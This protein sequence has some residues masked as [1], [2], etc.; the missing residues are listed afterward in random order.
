MGRAIRGLLFA[1][2]A[3]VGAYG[4]LAPVAD[5]LSVPTGGPKATFADS[6]T[7]GTS[8]AIASFEAAAGGADNGTTAGE[9][10]GGFRHVN[11]DGLAVDGSDPGSTVIKGG[12]VAAAPSRLQPWGLEL[13]PN[14]AISNN[15][16]QSV[17]TAHFTPFS[18]PN[19]WGTF[20]TGTAEFDV[21]A[22]VG[23]GST[24][25]PAQTRGLGIVFLNATA[26]TQITYYNG[27]IALDSVSPPASSGPSFAGLLYPDP[28]VT[29]VVVTLGGGQ[30]FGYDGTTV[31]PGGSS[32]AAGD[33]V[34]LA[35]PAPARPTVSATAGVP[36]SP[37][38]DTFTN[39]G[40]GA[41][42]TI[43]WGDGTG[44]AGTIVPASGGA[45]N[46]TGTHAYAQTG[47]YTAKVVVDDFFGHEQS[48]QTTIQVGPRA[49]TTSVSCSPAPVAV[50]APTTCTATVAD[51]GGAVTPTGL[52]SFSTP[53]PGASFGQDGGCLLSSTAIAGL[54]ACQVRFTPGQL[55]PLQARITA[56]YGGDGAHAGSGGIASV[57]V[58][59]QRCSVRALSRRLR[60]AGLGLLV[61]CDA[62]SSVRISVTAVGRRAGASRS[63]QLPFGSL[64]ALVTEGRPTV[65]V[66]KPAAGVEPVLRAALRRHQPVS[67][68]LALT[69]SSHV[70][71][72]TTTTRLAAV[73]IL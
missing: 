24:A 29:R 14:I 20:N 61:T 34:L 67:L 18:A 42:A 27:S 1:A 57:G 54:S 23:Q 59:A 65:L 40:S 2:L 26:S 39:D 41:V 66:V 68:R 71:R 52:V 69:A 73:R 56:L 4:A 16:F 70:T 46:V 30:I 35:E 9:Q 33:D 10:G 21:V 17:S 7:Q 28:V 63:F 60:R 37:V 48:S 49:S 3:V 11:W 64:R 12:V 53:T 55:P 25:T 5:A 31:T 8:A 36:I 13:G 62:R 19:M 22:P 6:G 38:L 51:V 32:A 43:D 47:T 72:R 45:F 44:T 58:H 15:G 50:S